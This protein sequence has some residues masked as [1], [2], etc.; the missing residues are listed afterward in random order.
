MCLYRRLFWPGEATCSG[1][2]PRDL[3]LLTRHM[4]HTARIKMDGKLVGY[5][6]LFSPLHYITISGDVGCSQNT[7]GWW[8]CYISRLTAVSRIVPY[9]NISISHYQWSW[10]SMSAPGIYSVPVRVPAPCSQPQYSCG[11]HWVRWQG[12][13]VGSDPISRLE[14][15]RL[16]NYH[17][18]KILQKG[19][20]GNMHSL[21]PSWITKPQQVEWN[22]QIFCFYGQHFVERGLVIFCSCLHQYSIKY[23]QTELDFL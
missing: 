1:L 4:S 21:D 15:L 22:Y 17:P 9:L 14:T 5:L 6:L 3:C 23:Y 10:Q 12:W 11:Y 18:L 19:H 16:Y 7:G 2:E 8:L 20:Y 13:Y